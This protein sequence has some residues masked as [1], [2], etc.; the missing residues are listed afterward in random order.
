MVLLEPTFVAWW[1]FFSS[2]QTKKFFQPPKRYPKHP[3]KYSVLGVRFPRSWTVKDCFHVCYTSRVNWW[4]A[5][6]GAREQEVSLVSC[7]PSLM[8][9]NHLISRSR[10]FKVTKTPPFLGWLDYDLVVK[11]R[12]IMAAMKET[13]GIAKHSKIP[14]EHVQPLMLLNR[15]PTFQTWV[16]G[17]LPRIPVNT[18]SRASQSKPSF[19]TV[20]G[21]GDNPNSTHF[22]QITKK[23]HLPNLLWEGYCFPEASISYQSMILW[24][25]HGRNQHRFCK[26]LQ[27]SLKKSP[28]FS[29]K[30]SSKVLQ[31]DL[32]LD[33]THKFQ[34]QLIQ[35]WKR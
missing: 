21:R 31:H 1:R 20:S 24:P 11:V 32:S 25:S 34:I 12:K 23:K 15:V 13:L 27:L 5:F 16:V 3:S 10:P 6:F 7:G 8:N 33:E 28:I 35:W 30:M 4:V 19:A 14:Q 22:F 18:S 26:S 2:T 17:T 9:K 29:L